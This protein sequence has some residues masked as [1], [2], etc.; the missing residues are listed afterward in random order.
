MP[1]PHVGYVPINNRHMDVLAKAELF[2]ALADPIREIRFTNRAFWGL[3]GM[4]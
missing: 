1:Q 2:R 3:T 4:L